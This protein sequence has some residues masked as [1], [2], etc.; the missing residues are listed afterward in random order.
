MPLTKNGTADITKS[1]ISSND[2][3]AILL[4]IFP[5][6]IL[7]DPEFRILAIG[8]TVASDL[9]YAE[10]ELKDEG[11]HLLSAELPIALAHRLVN[12][13]FEEERFHLYTKNGDPI[14]VGFSGFYSGLFFDFNGFIVLRFRNLEEVK[15][16]YKRL[17]AKADELDQF[18]YQASHSLRGP[19]ATIKGLA[20]IGKSAKDRNDLDYIISQVSIFSETLDER[21][22]KLTYLAEADKEASSP[23]AEIDF[24][25][26]ENK[27]RETIKQHSPDIAI[28]FTFSFEAPRG[29]KTDDTLL[30]SLLMN[31]FSFLVSHF[32]KKENNLAMELF[33]ST[34]SIEIMIRMHGFSFSEEERKLLADEIYTYA[35]LLKRP[36]MV[37]CYAA[38]KIL[39]KMQGGISFNFLSSEDQ[40]IIMYLPHH[41]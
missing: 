11:I 3:F 17:E 18:I 2:L 12:G 9:G 27:L 34:S 1:L 10:H 14:L 26:I 5:D 40:V 7:L 32:R 37:F 19:L 4:H 31:L 22:H 25:E 28:N 21:L 8:G 15:S 6:Y 16:F 29:Y 36:D 20:L 38:H 13:Y 35:E 39:I 24:L 33:V 30:R 41:V 23:P